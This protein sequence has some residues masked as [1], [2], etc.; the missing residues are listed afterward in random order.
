MSI[1]VLF[2]TKDTEVQLNLLKRLS[3]ALEVRLLSLRY[4]SSCAE[5]YLRFEICTLILVS[6]EQNKQPPLRS[7]QIIQQVHLSLYEGHTSRISLQC[8]LYSIF[9]FLGQISSHRLTHY[10]V[11]KSPLYQNPLPSPINNY[12]PS[13]LY[14]IPT[15]KTPPYPSHTKPSSAARPLPHQGSDSLKLLSISYL[16]AISLALSPVSIFL[17]Q[18]LLAGDKVMWD[19]ENPTQSTRLPLGCRWQTGHSIRIGIFAS[20]SG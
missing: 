19:L 13:N 18:L 5:A 6:R 8:C 15:P 11:D 7:S 16:W 1:V 4:A 9:S 20:F 10:F 2:L 17:A 12:K 3:L 14:S